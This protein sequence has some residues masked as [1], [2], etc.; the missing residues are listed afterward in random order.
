M[1]TTLKEPPKCPQCGKPLAAGALAGLCPAC[2]LAQGAET[3]PAGGRP[4]RHFEPPPIADIA[5][6]FPHLEIIDLL[7]AGG[8]GAVYKAR[9]SSLD[10]IVALKILPARNVAGANFAERFNREAR[11]LARLSHPNIVAVHEFGQVGGLHYFIMEFVDGANLR[12]LE[13]GNRLSPREALQI[14]PQVCDALQYAHDEGVVHRDIKPENVLVDRKGR[15]KIADFGLAKMLDIDPE[16]TRLTAEG[17]VMGTPHYMAPE[18]VER[19]LSVDHRADIYSLGVVLYEML[20]GDL[21]LGNFSPP[22]RKVRVDVRFDE[23]VLRALENDP[24]RRYQR[25]SDVKAKVET[26]AVPPPPA[27]TISVTP[28]AA[29][30]PSLESDRQL[31]RWCGIPVAFEKAGARRLNWPGVLPAI[32]ITFGILTL[33]F[34]LVTMLT[35]SSVFGWLGIKGWQS[36]V[37]RLIITGL[38]VA[39]GILRALRQP[40][41]DAMP[42]TPD[43]TTVLPQ[44]LPWLARHWKPVLIAYLSIAGWIWFQRHLLTYLISRFGSASAAYEA[45]TDP[46]S[47]VLIAELPKGA[48]VELLAVS[49]ADA[50]PDQWWR[51][52]GAPV[53]NSTFEVE[54][55]ADMNAPGTQRKEL[56]LRVSGIP[57]NTDPPLYDFT[58]SASISAGGTVLENGASLI[59]GLPVRAA[60]PAQA[61]T[62]T[63]RLGYRLDPWRTIATFDVNTRSVTQSGLAGDPHWTTSF[64]HISDDGTNTYV[65]MVLNKEDKQWNVRTVAVDV[66]GKD[67][68][69]NRASGTPAETT[70]TWTYTFSNVTVARLREIQIQVRPVQW[71]EFRDVA[72]TPRWRVASRIRPATG[73][74]QPEQV[75]ERNSATGSLA[76]TLPD[77]GTVELLALGEP[78]AAPTGWWTPDGAPVTQASFKVVDI[79]PV[80]REEGRRPLDVIFRLSY[81]SNNTSLGGI[82]SDSAFEITGAGDVLR[83]GQR[84]A[85]GKPIQ[86]SWPTDLRTADLRG[87]FGIGEWKTL[88]RHEPVTR[89]TIL[90]RAPGNPDLGIVLHNASNS[91]EGVEVTIAMDKRDQ[92]WRLRVVGADTNG[93]EHVAI[94]LQDSVSAGTLLTTWRIAGLQVMQIRDL[95]VQVQRVHRVQF[96]DVNL[97]PSRPVPPPLK[98]SF[99]QVNELKF[100]EL[101]DLDTDKVGTFPTDR[102]ARSFP[103]AI[104]ANVA[105]MQERGF[106]AEARTETIGLLGTRIAYLDERDWDSMS[107]ERLRFILRELG[108]MPDELQ[109][110]MKELPVTIGFRTR[111]GATGVLQVI[112]YSGDR[113]GATIRFKKLDR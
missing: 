3:D 15:V 93:T 84:L 20:T 89:S 33:L 18:Q 52:K 61:R 104:A 91:P 111:E 58:P 22:S 14:I 43:G 53:T 83:D 66:D 2:L 21:P 5:R 87:A 94:R 110:P 99:G 102:A 90:N 1:N 106:D 73:S 48:R 42:R 112:A 100:S 24:A 70:S 63:I 85:G 49:D 108:S 31:L 27:K 98:S 36:V 69:H 86:I 9:Q 6:L 34:A 62:A 38:V 79:C 8:M 7:G 80:N 68:V 113:P 109:P 65:T 30:A 4:G 92:G 44:R 64:N 57:A 12:M 10:R 41:P 35:D 81:L 13:Q 97:F 59:G 71:V 77:G 19:P 107:P 28:E 11:A 74:Q 25:A 37:A 26:I 101:L 55:P 23:V 45:Y 40:L 82:E 60:W 96:R 29:A 16:S 56:A 78:E 47:G 17:Q 95:H 50:N 75:A 39:W 105:W 76:A 32:G 51:P 54:G 88:S 67:R 72:L 46:S 103:E